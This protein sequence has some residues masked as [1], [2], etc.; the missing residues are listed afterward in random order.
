VTADQVTVL[1]GAQCALF[2]VA[3]CVLNRAMK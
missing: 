1:A 2:C 3:Q